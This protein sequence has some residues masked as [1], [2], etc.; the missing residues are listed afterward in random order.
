MIT[1]LLDQAG[2]MGFAPVASDD[3]DPGLGDYLSWITE[4]LAGKG[5]DHGTFGSIGLVLGEL[6]PRPTVTALPRQ[7]GLRR[8]IAA[9][10]RLRADYAAVERRPA[11]LHHTRRAH[12]SMPLLHRALA[13]PT[14]PRR[15][16][17]CRSPSP[18]DR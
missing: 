18:P 1:E 13:A 16:R 9:T 6:C 14:L 15:G 17:P 12:V 3:N 5:V 8:A 2:R 7:H 11:H 4:D 10:D